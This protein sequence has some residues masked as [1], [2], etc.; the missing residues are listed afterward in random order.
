[1]LPSE[2]LKELVALA[3]GAAKV[4]KYEGE[5][6]G[7]YKDEEGQLYAVNTTPQIKCSVGWNS[8]ERSWDC[9]CRGSRFT[10]EGKL[11]TA[12]AVAY[13]QRINLAASD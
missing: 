3:K 4:V 13:L 1:V 11:L 7:I 12:P 2:K 6:M 8:A 9:P 5:T 10:Y